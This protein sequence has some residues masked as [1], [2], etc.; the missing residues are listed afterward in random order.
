M[1]V[2]QE[3]KV[4]KEIAN[5][6]YSTVARIGFKNGDKVKTGDVVIELETSKAVSA[7]EAEKDGYIEYFCKEG[8][9]VARVR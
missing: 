8:D 2:V 9:D 7:I 1:S 3:I 4:L 5:D 6:E